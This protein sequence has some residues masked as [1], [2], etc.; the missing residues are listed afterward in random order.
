MLVANDLTLSDGGI[1]DDDVILDCCS[2]IHLMDGTWILIDRVEFETCL[3]SGILQ[4]MNIP[5]KLIPIED[6]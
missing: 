1:T 2:Q 4:R 3:N 5:I 6:R